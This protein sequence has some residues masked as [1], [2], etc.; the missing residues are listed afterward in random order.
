MLV[1]AV[2]AGVALLSLLVYLLLGRPRTTAPT[3]DR[4][5]LPCWST[6]VTLVAAFVVSRPSPTCAAEGLRCGPIVGLEQPDF[7]PQVAANWPALAQTRS[8]EL[9]AADRRPG[10]ERGA[11]QQEL[12]PRGTKTRMGDAVRSLVN[13]ERGGPIAGIILMTDGGKQRR[14]RLQVA[15]KAATVAGIPDLRRGTGQR[16]ATGQRA[17]RRPGS[18]QTRLPGRQVQPDRVRPGARTGRAARERRTVFR[19]RRRQR[20]RD[21]EDPTENATF[22]EEQ[23]VRLG[24]DG[25]V[26][27]VNFEVTPNE[28]GTWQYFLKARPAGQRHGTA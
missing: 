15:A 19:T 10:A 20:G 6:M 9:R 17:R 14:G 18:A 28:E 11:W 2:L 22:E 16:S 7:E 24:G 27:T 21:D 13:Q 23:T 3:G 25:E 5:R 26:V 4:P 12:M 1:A 8:A